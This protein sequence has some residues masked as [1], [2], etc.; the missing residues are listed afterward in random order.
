MKDSQKLFLTVTTMTTAILVSSEPIFARGG[1]GANITNSPGYQRRLH[2]SRQQLLQPDVQAAIKALQ[3]ANNLEPDFT[4]QMQSS[5]SSITFGTYEKPYAKDS[6]WNIR[7]VNPVLS[8]IGTPASFWQPAAGP[9][10]GLPAGPMYLALPTDPPMV[11]HP[12]NIPD[13]VINEPDGGPVQSVTI[14]HWPANVFGYDGA[15]GDGW[16]DIV[17][18]ANNIVYSLFGLSNADG[19]WRIG[20]YGWTKLN[21]RGWGDPAHFY[22]GARA[23][24]ITVWGGYIR[25]KEI[26]DGDVMYRHALTMSM[27]PE[28]LAADPPYV[29]PAT[30]ADYDAGANTGSIPEGALMMLPSD[31]DVSS[32]GMKCLQK[33]ARTL[34]TYGGY[35]TDKNMGTPYRIEVE[36]G[37]QAEAEWCKGDNLDYTYWD[38]EKIRDAMRMVKSTSGWVDIDGNPVNR[39]PDGLPILSLRGP[40]DIQGPAT[41]TVKYQTLS[42]SVRFGPTGDTPVTVRNTSTKIPGWKIL[43]EQYVAG[44]P[45]RLTVHATGDAKMELHIVTGPNNEHVFDTGP[46]GDGQSTIFN[47]PSGGYDWLIPELTSGVNVA[48]SSVSIELVKVINH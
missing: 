8:S 1:G 42:Q 26:N 19:T 43:W 18:P 23:T 2:E 27:P 17:D 39:S 13:A 12:W 40:W 34:Q 7:P 41:T 20:L 10:W 31:F 14:P 25:T 37:P 24:G 3:K 45:Y 32:L 33:V 48:S 16:A 6:P 30:S 46:L 15:I 44:D 35:V 47:W 11:L 22:T 21:G 5:T 29:F 38:I 4:T 9:A 36:S 28:S